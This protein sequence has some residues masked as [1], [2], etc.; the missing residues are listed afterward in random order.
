MRQSIEWR[1][2]RRTAREALV[3]FEWPLAV[4]PMAPY[5]DLRERLN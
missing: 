5:L 1:Q 3:Q 2:I 4:P